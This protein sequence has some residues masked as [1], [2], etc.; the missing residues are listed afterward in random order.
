[1]LSVAFL[2]REKWLTVVRALAEPEWCLTED[3]RID[4]YV[5]RIASAPTSEIDGLVARLLEILSAESKESSRIFA[6][7]PESVST[8]ELNILVREGENFRLMDK[9][10]GGA[11]FTNARVIDIDG[12][13]VEFEDGRLLSVYGRTA[14]LPP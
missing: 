12:L 6:G 4:R 7:F 11:G 13:R 5:G 14:T 8:P 1:M 3:E 2:R 9:L 10:Q